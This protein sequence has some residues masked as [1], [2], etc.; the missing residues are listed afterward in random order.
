MRHVPTAIYIDTEVFFRNGLR[1]DTKDFVAIRETFVKKGLRLLVPEMMERELFRHF[2]RRAKVS[3]DEVTK[4]HQQHPIDLLE[5]SPLPPIAE[6]ENRCFEALREKWEVFKDHFTVEILPLVG[7]LED[8]VDWYFSIEAPFAEGKKAKEF[9]DAFILSVIEDYC[10]RHSSRVAVVSFDGDFSTACAKRSSISHFERIGSYIDAFKP[11]LTKTNDIDI[12]DPTKPIATEDLTEIKA[13]LGR[14]SEITE[15]ER[16]RVLSLLSTRGSNYD[17]FFR[18]AGDA[19]WVDPLRESGFFSD[20]P[21]TERLEDGRVRMMTWWPMEYLVRIFE[22]APDKVVAVLEALPKTDNARILEGI[23]A[24]I[25]KC[26]DSTLFLKFYDRIESY[27]D[28]AYRV[29]D[30]INELLAQPYLFR[31]HLSDA[32]SA[33]LLKIVEF[34]PDPDA[35]EKAERRQKDPNDWTTSLKPSPRFGAWDY[36]QILKHGVCPL[37]DREPFTV[38]RVLIDA[39]ASM[40]RL[41]LH[42]GENEDGSDEDISEIWCRRLDLP[43]RDI[44]GPDVNL[45]HA[46]IESCKAVFDK[47]QESVHALD[48]A[49]RNQ[50]WKVFTRVRQYL[51]AL[52]PTDKT[53]PGIRE[54]ILT[55]DDYDKW[56]YH[57]EFQLL[58][59]KAS[60]HFGNR[61]LSEGE[62][63]KIFEAILSGPS[64]ESFR[65]WMGDGYSE[66]AWRQRQ[67]YFHRKQLRPFANILFGSYRAYYDELEKEFF[68]DKLTD[69][70]FSPVGEVR[71]GTVTYR[72]PKSI[73]E[74]QGLGD[75][76][77]LA[78]I[79]EWDTPHRDSDDWLIE[80]NIAAL[81]GAFQAV[82]KDAIVPVPTRL[83]FWFENR[84][85]IERP[86][87]VKAMV[88]AMQT[89][90]KEKWF[91][92][93]VDWLGFCDWILDRPNE[94]PE[95]DERQSDESRVNPDWRSCR[96]TVGDF[97]DICLDKD[98][99]VPLTARDVL[100][101]LLRKL[102]TQFDYW[103]DRD[104]PALLNR[105][106][107]VTVAINNTRSRALEDLVDFGFWVRRY[108]EDADVPELREILE[109]RFAADSARP[110][111]LPEHALLGL[112]FGRIWSLANDWTEVNKFNFFPQDDFPIWAESFSA[113]ISFSQPFLRIF[114]VL[115]GDFAFALNHLGALERAGGKGRDVTDFLGQ[116]LFTYY[117]W[118]VYPLR[119]DSSLLN[120]F[121]IKTADD[122]THWGRLLDHVGRT[123]R[124]TAKLDRKLHERVIEFFEWRLQE[125]EPLELQEFTFWLE[126]TCLDPDWR[127]DTYSNILDSIQAKNVALSIQLGSLNEMLESHTAKV[128]ECFAK[129]TDSLVPN[130]DF[131]IQTEKAKPILLAG[132][133]STDKTIQANAER[134]R[135]NLLKN[136]RFD[137][138]DIQ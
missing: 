39:T 34:R 134:A 2:Q 41:R 137:F 119:G 98:V 120:A 52:N 84:D 65:E 63:I 5:L 3:A 22:G 78:C 117:L 116:H 24:I 101:A 43:T 123:L 9:P 10:R 53:L 94:G 124:N 62:R 56:D 6:L 76:E 93:L 20:P 73:E 112:H 104:R 64:I 115:R 31:G 86:I 74:L 122:R 27:L 90:T 127:L 132:L 121:Y 95:S 15:I 87:Y 28:S 118:D 114:E 13:I 138:L 107:Q 7:R 37:A 96:R 58:I 36:Q 79:N 29:H 8:V 99:Q 59:R 12:I 80:I 88:Q 97:V 66:D 100:A 111:T 50:R 23:L 1:F 109:S 44:G 69:D 128:V 45:V 82:F 110:L 67:H 72:S 105:D 47:A 4:A 25:L 108:E 18:Y 129:V 19:I 71:G 135:E 40:I 89:I 57:Y 42:H 131:Y 113:F 83:A 102:C 30:K 130:Q 54:F 33:L 55:H 70:S 14:G 46:L 51:Y 68:Q 17:Y 125:A 77:L 92:Q 133:N 32:S 61:L 35:E 103:L 21:C 106:D 49:L 126:A 26:D 16:N 136:G 75:Q 81:A 85:R 11:E 60:E 38:A 48:Q 91:E